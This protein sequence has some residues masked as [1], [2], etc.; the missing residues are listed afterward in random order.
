MKSEVSQNRC[1]LCGVVTFDIERWVCL[2]ITE[3]G[4]LGHGGFKRDA[5]G[6]H[7]VKNVIRRTVNDSHYSLNLVA[8]KRFAQRANNWNGGGDCGLEVELSTDLLGGIEQLGAV[9][10]QESLVGRDDVAARVERLQDVGSCRF[11][12]THDFDD[13]VGAQ[14]QALDIGG[15]QF[16]RKTFGA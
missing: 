10:C 4:C 2:E 16:G 6:I 7:A 14:N 8:G 5:C 1:L 15:D 13:N 12:T 11:D 3:L 9:C